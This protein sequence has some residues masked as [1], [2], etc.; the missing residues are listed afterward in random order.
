M[1][2]PPRG[3]LSLSIAADLELIKEEEEEVVGSVVMIIM[4][5]L[6]SQDWFINDWNK[7]DFILSPPLTKFIIG[8][9]VLPSLLECYFLFCV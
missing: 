1:Q 6:K 4:Q 9:S 3:I 5:A 2:C 7:S 8:E